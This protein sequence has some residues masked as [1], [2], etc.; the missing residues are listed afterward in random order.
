LKKNKLQ[1]MLAAIGSI[2][3]LT[4]GTIMIIQIG[5]NHQVNKQIIDQCF[6]SFDSERTVTIK[7]EGFWSPVS[8]E[9]HPGA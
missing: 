1:M 2:A 3:I 9:K 6:E 7:K 4:I 8:C 5:K